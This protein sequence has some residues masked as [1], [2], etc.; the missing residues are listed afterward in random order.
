MITKKKTNLLLSIILFYSIAFSQDNL[1]ALLPF[2]NSISQEKGVFF[3]SKN[4]SI[5]IKSEVLQF[6]GKELQSIIKQHF[7]FTPTIG[8]SGKIQLQLNPNIKNR[9]QYILD[10][11][12]D[13]ITI[14]GKNPA[15]ILYGIMTLEQLLLGDIVNTKQQ[16]IQSIRIEDAPAYPFRALMLDPA[17]HFLP[18]DDIKFYIDQMMR[19]KYNALQ[20]HLTDDQGWRIEIKNYPKLTDIGALRN[21]KEIENIADNGFYT[22]KELKDLIEYASKRNI[23]IIPEIDIPGHTAAILTAYPDLR[24]D[25][26]KDSIFTLG[27]TDNVMLSAANP[28]VYEVLDTILYEIANIFP[29][30]KIHLGGDESAIDSNWAK[31]PEN[32]QLMK[33]YGYSTPKELMNIFFG[34]VF[35]SVNKYNLQ[36]TLW[37]ELD[38]IRMPANRFL[39]D[40]PPN[41]TLVTWRYGL[42]PKCIELTSKSNH[43]L[44]LAPG[45]YCYF[46]YPQY[47]ND[48]PEYNNWGMPT[49]T[50]R[51]V[52]NFDPT[53]D[54][55]TDSI[56]HI[57]G[58]M[59]TL[60]GE[61]IKDINRANYMT[62]P[63][64]LAL[65]EAG[66]TQSKYRSWNSFKK[67]LYPNLSF[68]MKQGISLRVP[69]EIT[70]E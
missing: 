25:F 56:K 8:T 7:N 70:R 12:T 2:P 5:S 53:Y 55:P 49:T 61:A 36:A 17:R 1:S 63:R 47:Q 51:Q 13:S 69:F 45:E 67:R 59:G 23:E 65:A 28:R 48:L 21:M 42:T 6:A 43:D 9:E 38:N 22:Q 32:L 57:K 29:S 35:N 14:K 58:V 15:G 64:S 11:T 66:W 27:K 34:K 50:L 41:I 10:I 40:Y 4:D 37:C 46:D 62:Y 39:F 24:C 3:L 26:L 31:S 44:I 19:Y 16:R 60:W 18:I 68:L 20:L 54:L 52:Y 33:K 30:K